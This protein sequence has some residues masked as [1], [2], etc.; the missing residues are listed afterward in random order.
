MARRA[1]WLHLTCLACEVE[2]K[3]S[4]RKRNW[5]ASISSQGNQQWH[6]WWNICYWPAV[7]WQYGFE[8]WWCPNWRS[9][10]PIS[11]CC[12]CH[13][14]VWLCLVSSRPPLSSTG[15]VPL[16]IVWK[17]TK[18]FKNRSKSAAKISLQKDSSFPTNDQQRKLFF[19]WPNVNLYFIWQ[20]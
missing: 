20:M 3:C 19:W 13:C 16:T 1:N 5:Q 4:T 6:A 14:T 15:F 17:P 8:C 11:T 10:F 12:S 9:T 2:K 7:C 18:N